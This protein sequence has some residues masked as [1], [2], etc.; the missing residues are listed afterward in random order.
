[1][2]EIKSDRLNLVSNSL[3]TKEVIIN[4]GEPQILNGYDVAKLLTPEHLT[5]NGADKGDFY[6]T[7]RLPEGFY[8]FNFYLVD[9]YRNITVA[10]IV[11]AMAFL[12]L[13]DPPII[14]EPR[15]GQKLRPH[16]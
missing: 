4:S 1:M 12:V 7:G 6:R 8:T 3:V 11:P 5:I 13:N 16:S 15:Q 9:Y 14:N 10:Q 2:V